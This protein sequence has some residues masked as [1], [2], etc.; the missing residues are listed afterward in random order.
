MLM[1]KLGCHNN[2]ASERSGSLFC[3]PSSFDQKTSHPPCS[4][5][6]KANQVSEF[7]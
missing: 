3:A 1:K 2:L 5:Y 4:C 6:R 7:V